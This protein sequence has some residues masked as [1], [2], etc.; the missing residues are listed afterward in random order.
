MIDAAT[1]AVYLGWEEENRDVKDVAFSGEQFR[2]EERLARLAC[3]L[4]EEQSFKAL[5]TRRSQARRET[6]TAN[7]QRHIDAAADATS[8]AGADAEPCQQLSADG[9]WFYIIC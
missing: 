2:Q 5:Q 9:L 8:E 6:A 1:H 4:Q 3:A 7:P